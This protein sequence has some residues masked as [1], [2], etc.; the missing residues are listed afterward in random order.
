MLG[1]S[2]Q[3]GPNNLRHIDIPGESTHFA[4]MDT[5]FYSEPAIGRLAQPKFHWRKSERYDTFSLFN[6]GFTRGIFG[7]NG[8][9]EFV[10]AGIQKFGFNT[11]RF[12]RFSP[13]AVYPT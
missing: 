13:T 8:L 11:S 6:G 9:Q 7:I 1:T 12:Q 3:A 10:S 5:T 4:I 2:D